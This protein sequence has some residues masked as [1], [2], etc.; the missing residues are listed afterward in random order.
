MDF[1]TLAHEY[2]LALDKHRWKQLEDRNPNLSL[3]TWMTNGFRFLILDRLRETNRE[4]EAEDIEQRAANLDLRFDI[5]DNHFS[6]DVRDTVEDMCDRLLGRDN[7]KAI[8][9]RM[10]LVEGFKGKE[11]AEELGMTPS[12][13]TQQYHKLMDS[14][15]IPY[16]KKHY[17]LED[18]M[19]E[20]L[21]LGR[22]DKKSISF[23]SFGDGETRFKLAPRS[24]PPL[25]RITPN[26]IRSLA[27]NEIFVFGSNLA[28]MHGG[29]AA[30]RA[31]LRFGAKIGQGVGLQGQSYAIPTM[32]GDTDTISPYVD[33]FVEFAETRPELRF[34]VTRIGC[35]LAGFDPED[36]APLFREAMGVKNIYLPKDFWD[37]LE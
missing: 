20:A 10:I 37:E 31:R 15:V 23:H 27:E 11:V 33:D 25:R 19:Q 32:L 12:A 14:V 16:F 9:L 21:C 35:G 30:R 6:Q 13:V 3:K 18:F 5:P 24:L 34:L 7:K 22:V 4:F 1:Y 2:Y 36:I 29:G 28:G 26:N 8:I 17:V